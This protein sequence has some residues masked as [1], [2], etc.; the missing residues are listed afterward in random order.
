VGH[1][2]GGCG[3]EA[4]ASARELRAVWMPGDL[5]PQDVWFSFLKD[6]ETESS[7]AAVKK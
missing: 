6:D 4:A 5:P 3:C 1:A 7:L 2:S